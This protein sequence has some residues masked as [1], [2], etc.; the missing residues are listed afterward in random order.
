MD[1]TKVT[2]VE[3]IDH[4]SADV[5]KFVHPTAPRYGWLGAAVSID[6]QD[7][8]RTLKVFLKDSEIAT[9]T[10]VADE[11]AAGLSAA[12]NRSLSFSHL[13]DL[14]EGERDAG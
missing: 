1:L 12:M 14:L 2:R 3:V 4:T 5:Y 9:S 10:E 8:G 11:M 7:D 13:T 6:V